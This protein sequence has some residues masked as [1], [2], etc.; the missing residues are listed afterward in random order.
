ML[1]DTPELPIILLEWRRVLRASG[2]LALVSLVVPDASNVATRLYGWAHRNFSTLVDCR[3]INARELVEGA[4]FEVTEARRSSLAGLAVE[5][6]L[7]TR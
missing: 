3:P 6:L 5:T 7:A 2:R 1:F 4:G